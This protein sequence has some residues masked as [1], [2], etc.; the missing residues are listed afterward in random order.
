MII[1]IGARR[2]VTADETITAIEAALEEIGASRNDVDILASAKMKEN[3]T[4]L[5]EAAKRLDLDIQF[6][7]HEVLNR[8]NGPSESQARRF[9]LNGVAE[10]SAL[11]LSDNNLLIMKKKAYGRITIAIAE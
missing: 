3:E 8:F 5:I 6:I 4:G 10:P 1:G 7:P 9:G 11:A 2:G